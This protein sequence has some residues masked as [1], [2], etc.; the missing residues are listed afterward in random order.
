MLPGQTR[1]MDPA[2]RFIQRKNE[3]Q[4]DFLNRVENDTH[5]VLLQAKL[6]D[7]YGVCILQIQYDMCEH[8]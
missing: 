1:P 6:S 4:K 8:D 7:K 3:K 5:R 2:P